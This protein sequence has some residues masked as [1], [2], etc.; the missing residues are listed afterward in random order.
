MRNILVF[1]S[2]SV[3]FIA[4]LTDFGY[5]RWLAPQEAD[6]LIYI[7]R[8]V[9]WNAPEYHHRG[10]KFIPATRTD[11]FSIGVYDLW[12]LFY[13]VSCSKRDFMGDTAHLEPGPM[14]EL[15]K[16]RVR[17]MSDIEE[18]TKTI[19]RQVFDLCVAAEPEHRPAI[20]SILQLFQSAQCVAIYLRF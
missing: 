3:G 11:V 12:L 20:N 6:S 4:K 10:F 18:E 2:D 13:N 1:K 7:P 14:V 17:E 19:L 8:S 9:P 5:S 16:T 15:A